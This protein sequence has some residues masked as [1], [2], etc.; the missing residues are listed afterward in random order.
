MVA[1]GLAAV[2][3]V[4][5][6]FISSQARLAYQETVKKVDVYNRFRYALHQ[7]EKDLQA[8]IPTGDLEFFNDGRG[9]RRVNGH[10]APGEEAPDRPDEYGPGQVDGGLYKSYEEFAHIIQR[11]YVSREPL[12]AEEKVH[13]AY[14][15]YFRTLT[16]VDGTIREANVE[17]LLL[18]P[19][20][21]V[22][23][24]PQPP[25]RIERA[26][27]VANLSLYKIVRYQVLSHDMIF[28]LQE[29]PIRRKLLEVS[30]NVTDFRVEY[31]VDK[32]AFS[33]ASP[34][35]RTPEEDFKDPI[36]AV[37]RPRR[38][39]NVGPRPG[40]RK[41]FGYGSAKLE[42]K[43]PLAIAQKSRRGDDQLART[44]SDHLPVKFGFLNVRE[45]TFAELTPGDGVFVFLDPNQGGGGQSVQGLEV[46]GSRRQF[47]PG[48]YTVRSNLNG[49]MEFQEDIDSTDWQN[50]QQSGL[51]SKAPFLPSAVRVTI[52]VV[53]DQGQNPKTLQRVIWLRRRSR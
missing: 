1:L 20:K 40:Y 53:D 27:D 24:M 43:Y 45:I 32:S 13:D 14:Q 26:E 28:N 12:Q 37:T 22:G 16:Y 11:H 2:I 52:R 33:K 31:L 4:S 42:E 5:I 6:M 50:Q 46:A 8:W 7:I 21:M 41:I 39:E 48:D 38:L 30:T 18:D 36:E 23:Q 19:K 44:G 15:L 9:G 29:N 25:D 47:P 35:F 34:T 49:L 17:Y 3:S 51:Y 10:W